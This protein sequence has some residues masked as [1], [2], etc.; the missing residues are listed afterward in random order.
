MSATGGAEKIPADDTVLSDAVAAF[1]HRYLAD[2]IRLCLG[3]SGGQDSVVLLHVL[4]ALIPEKL[5]AIHVHHGFFPED[6]AWADFCET[7]C[8]KRSIPL[9][10]ARTRIDPEVAR[11]KGLEAAARAARY[12]AYCAHGATRPVAFAL[13]HH[14]RDQAETLLLRLCRGAG[15]SGAAGMRA[16]QTRVF[17]GK[18]LLFLRPLLEQGKAAIEN[19]A[20]RHDLEW[21]EDKS[22]QDVSFRRNALRHRVFPALAPFFP[23]AEANFSRAARHFSEAEQL[24]SELAESDARQI[25]ARLEKLRLLS[26]ARQANWLRY[27]LK[28]AGW[29]TPPAARLSEVLRQLAAINPADTRFQENL[30]EGSLRLWRGT[31]YRV[32]KSLPPSA[33]LLAL[34]SAEPIS[35]GGGRVL[36]EARVGEGIDTARLMRARKAGGNLW[37]RPRQGGEALQTAPN[38]PRR[39]LK[40]LLREAGIPPWLRVNWPLLYLENELIAAP[41][42]GVRADWQCLS[43]DTGILPVFR[44][45][46]A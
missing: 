27:W 16:A 15:L 25:G 38:R 23:A 12:Q 6:D 4:A 19:Y 8:R 24:L 31:L 37:L 26:P 41:A 32:P 30:P 20:R 33:V 35:W 13:A 21:M 3:L 45:P 2:E 42:L 5:S 11:R 46:S 40:A 1:L 36:W 14:Q 18:S 34:E 17:Q 10:V 7:L 22:N 44:S 43:G 39:P 28:D 29:Q 9:T